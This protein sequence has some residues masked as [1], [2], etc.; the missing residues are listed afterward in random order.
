MSVVSNEPADVARRI[1][2]E[3]KRASGGWREIA[4]AMARS[5]RGR[6]GFT[7]LLLFAIDFSDFRFTA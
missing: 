7:L 1:R 2:G 5:G 3:G 4:A 6:V